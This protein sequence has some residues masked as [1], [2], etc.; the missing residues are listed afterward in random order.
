MLPQSYELPAAVLLV[1][2]GLLSCFAG[3]RLFRIVL[4]LYGFVLGAMLASS[5]MGVTN[6]TGMIV[7]SMVGGVCGALLLIFAYFIGIALVGAGLGALV[8]HVA[9]SSV[10]KGGDPPAL[11]IVVL[12]IAGS[13]AAMFLQRYVIVVATAFGGA[14]TMIIGG[15]ALA[16]E[17]TVAA[18][19]ASATSVWILYPTS[20]QGQAW[21]PIAWV[22]L[23]LI[24]AGVQLGV[25]GRKRS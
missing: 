5:A 9:W 2:G 10:G 7:A 4:G 25:T 6:T 8:A 23:G 21:V 16:A 13:I 3:Y 20:A 1:F 17:R 24:G 18:K 15:L 12:S 19:S 11:A 22:V 14:W